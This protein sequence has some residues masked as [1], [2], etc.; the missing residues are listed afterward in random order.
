MNRRFFIG[1]LAAALVGP[2]LLFPVEARAHADCKPL[3]VLYGGALDNMTQIVRAVAIEG[4]ISSTKDVLQRFRDHVDMSYYYHDE[5][6][7][8]R[9]KIER[10]Q[11]KCPDFP[12]VLQGIEN[13]LKV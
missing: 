6:N 11:I 8:S 12:V 1:A 9:V 2:L 5:G 7:S 3:L 4:I 10:H 13:I